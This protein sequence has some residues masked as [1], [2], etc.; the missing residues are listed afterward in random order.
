MESVEIESGHNETI[1][2]NLM[3]SRNRPSEADI[4]IVIDYTP[5]G[6]PSLYQSRQYF[7]F[8]GMNGDNWEWVEQPIGDLKQAAE[9]QINKRVR[10]KIPRE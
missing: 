5:W 8:L 10:M 2:C 1:S 4:A 6:F 9:L 3:R 7:R